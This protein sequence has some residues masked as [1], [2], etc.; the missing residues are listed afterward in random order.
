MQK[1]LDF[2]DKIPFSKLHL[3]RWLLH[4][5]GTINNTFKGTNSTEIQNRAE[6][7]GRFI[8]YKIK[9]GQ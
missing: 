4:W 8:M 3:E 2:N 6:I 5:K 9:E 7:I 1:H